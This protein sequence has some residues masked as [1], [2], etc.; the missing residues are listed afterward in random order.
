MK[1][2]PW[3]FALL[4]CAALVGC[5]SSSSSS[6]PDDDTGANANDVGADTSPTTDAPL[7]DTTPPGDADE[8]GPSDVFPAPHPPLPTAKSHGGAVVAHPKIVPVIF[9]VDPL[10]ADIGTFMGAW[11]TTSYWQSMLADYGIDKPVVLD[12]AHVADAPA[13]AITDD[14]IQTWLA[15]QVD[16]THAGFPAPDADTLYALF[17]PPG[18]TITYPGLGAS[19]SA[20]H[21]YHG[22]AP[23][24]SGTDAVYSVISRCA[25]I[26]EDTTLT[27]IQ[28]VSAVTSHEVIEGLTD[29]FVM[30][31]PAWALI[32][33]AHIAWEL[34]PGGEVGDL[35][36]LVGEAFYTP[37]DFPYAVQRIWSNTAAA[38]GHDPCIVQQTGHVYF[39]A[40]PVVEDDVRVRD[41]FGALKTTK[42]VK[43]AIGETKTIEVDLFSDAPTSGPWSVKAIEPFAPTPAAHH[44]T[45]AWDR[46]IGA[47]GDKLHLTI[48]ALS[49]DAQ[50]G[51]EY[52]MIVSTLGTQRNFWPVFVG[53][54]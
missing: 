41:N 46:S 22:A 47:N 35:C 28:Y 26:P 30:T 13:S 6:Q 27:G 40:A 51:G 7:D 48:T 16:G 12:V 37:S 1:P 18:V 50:F 21:G 11:A 38:T 36:A 19:C 10:A 9:D 49:K 34:Y 2:D 44:L 20:F 53:Q 32:D 52:F 17:Y 42:G 15:A 24:P 54:S 43:L 3:I 45:L 31:T 14:D 33:D 39:N 29:P 23:T 8:S 4:A 5:G 25:S